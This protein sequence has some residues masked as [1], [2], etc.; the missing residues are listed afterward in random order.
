MK[1]VLVVF[2]SQSGQLAGI[3]DVMTEPLRA[4]GINVHYEV[5]RPEPAFSFPWRLS[6]FLDAFPESVWLDPRP[7]KPLEAPEVKGGYDLVIL[8]WTVW[9][10]SPSQPVAAFLLGDDGRRVLADKPVVSV[11]ACRNMWLSAFD[12]VKDL[13]QR[14]GGRLVDHVALTD[15]GS[16]LATF[17]TTPRWMLTGRRDRFLGLPPAG[18]DAVQVAGVARFGV[19]LAHALGRDEEKTG[20]PM[21]QGLRA[22]KVP[23]HL[24]LSERAGRRAFQVWS[25]LLRFFGRAGQWRRFP[26]L[27]LFLLYLVVMIMTVVPLSLALQKLA[28]PLLE[29]RLAA[30][31]RHYELPSGTGDERMNGHE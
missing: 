20:R 1:N 14:A 21:L 29:R 9:F 13:V 7:I 12:T 23:R 3:V 30:L 24:L 31:A 25:G 8:A 4:A 22:V 5:L 18:V 16:A 10:L 15:D 17:V 2:Y 27:L 11:V 28:A 6:G 26:M 19:A